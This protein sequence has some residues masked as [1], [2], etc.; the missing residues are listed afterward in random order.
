[1]PQ[2][3]PPLS[4]K[5][6]A[7]KIKQSYDSAID[8]GRASPF[9]FVTGAGIS[10]PQVPLAQAIIRDCKNLLRRERSAVL[11]IQRPRRVFPVA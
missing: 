1:M 11:R 5:S 4:L 10:A 9:F 8:K 7:G 2:L 3:T 6:A